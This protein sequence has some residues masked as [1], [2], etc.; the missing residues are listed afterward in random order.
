MFLFISGE[1]QSKRRSE[2]GR[3]QRDD[4]LSGNLSLQVSYLQMAMGWQNRYFGH[5]R[6]DNEIRCA[7]SHTADR[8]KRLGPVWCRSVVHEDKEQRL[9]AAVSFRP[10]DRSSSCNEGISQEHQ[11]RRSFFAGGAAFAQSY[12]F[13]IGVPSWSYREETGTVQDIVPER[14]TGSVSGGL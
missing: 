3:F 13:D 8:R 5:W 1:S 12:E 9:Q 7:R 2:R 4:G 6:Y 11:T 14:Y 10:S